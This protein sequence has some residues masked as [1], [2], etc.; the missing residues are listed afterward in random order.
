MGL[1]PLAI[2]ILIFIFVI[3]GVFEVYTKVQSKY[4][5]YQIDPN[6]HWLGVIDLN[7]DHGIDMAGVIHG[8]DAL[9]VI[10]Y[11]N[12][13]LLQLLQA[14]TSLPAEDALRRF[15]LGNYDTNR[16]GLINIDDPIYNFLK[17]LVFDPDIRGYQI[18]TLQEAGIRGIRI[19]HTLGQYR[20]LAVM[21]DGTTRALYELNQP[22]GVAVYKNAQ[23]TTISNLP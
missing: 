14:T 1:R 2:S 11:T 18:R 16:D 9:L 17:V 13:L 12:P 6:Q 19:E 5:A 10:D 3:I 20:H 7:D 8:D 21:S 23:G 22:G 15:E 4:L